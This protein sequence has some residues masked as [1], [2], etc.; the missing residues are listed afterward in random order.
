MEEHSQLEVSFKIT[1]TIN[2]CVF[3][4]YFISLELFFDENVFS[5]SIS[6]RYELSVESDETGG[7][8]TISDLCSSVVHTILVFRCPISKLRNF[9]PIKTH[10][11]A[12]TT[13]FDAPIFKTIV[14]DML[15]FYWAS[16][17]VILKINCFKYFQLS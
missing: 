15:I 14:F 9:L 5:H 3:S 1:C 8:L 17:F 10:G 11:Y 7:S 16:P 12:C 13:S 6:S 2:V 4:T